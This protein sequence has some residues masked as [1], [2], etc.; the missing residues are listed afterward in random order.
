[1]KGTMSERGTGVWRGD[2]CSEGA[3][4]LRAV[5]LAKGGSPS[6]TGLG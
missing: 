6:S 5:V 1:M 2:G 3:F 4:G